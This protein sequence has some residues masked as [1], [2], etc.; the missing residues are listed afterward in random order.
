MKINLYPYLEEGITDACVRHRCAHACLLS[1]ACACGVGRTRIR[2]ETCV[3]ADRVWLGSQAFSQAT[4][5]NANIGAWNVLRVTT[6]T[7][8][9]DG[10]GLADC[11]KRGMYDNWGS[12]LR[13]AYPT[14]SSLS[15]CTTVSPTAPPRY[16]CPSGCAL[17]V[18]AC[19][20]G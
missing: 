10:V 15:V 11:I 6:Y 17:L 5:F 7:S 4:A 8:A 9:F 19:K 3:G 20:C 13:A 14:W 1:C 12:T 16:S 2:A 18:S